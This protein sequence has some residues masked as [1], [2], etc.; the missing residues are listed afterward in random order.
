MK[1]TRATLLLGLCPGPG[2]TRVILD[3]PA[4]RLGTRPPLGVVLGN[5]TTC[6]E[7]EPEPDLP[8]IEVV[9]WA[10]YRYGDVDM[11]GING[12]LRVVVEGPLGRGR[13]G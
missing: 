13:E 8:Y 5:D 1:S 7:L 2:T 10:Q 4:S 11:T 12:V 9:T 6:P 3:A